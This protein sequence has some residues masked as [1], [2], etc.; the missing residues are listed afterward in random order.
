MLLPP[1]QLPNAIALS[2]A[3]AAAVIITHLFDTAIKQ[4]WRR[5][6]WLWQ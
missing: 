4:Q 6:Q 2:T 5:K 3:I 1:P